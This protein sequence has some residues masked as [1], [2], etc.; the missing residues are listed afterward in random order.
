MT[1]DELIAF[2]PVLS[3]YR[4]ATGLT[5]EELAE[6]AGLSVRGISDL[7]RGVNQSPRSYTVR[8]LADAL[9]LSSDDRA[10]FEHAARAASIGQRAAGTPPAGD[11]L[12]TLPTGPLIG[13][14]EELIHLRAVLDAVA[15]GAG[16]FIFLSGETG[17]GKTRLA[18]E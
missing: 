3:H 2:G 15:E 11:F 18:Q 13:R 8:R 5:Q 10:L 1:T 14:D 4:V 16:H 9:Q 17:V 7:E 6:R 12:G